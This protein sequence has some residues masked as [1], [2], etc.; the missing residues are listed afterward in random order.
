[1]GPYFQTSQNI[2]SIW[3]N[4]FIRQYFF[5]IQE[6]Y[7]FNKN[8]IIKNRVKKKRKVFVLKIFF[9]STKKKKNIN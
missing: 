9:D 2:A 6:K 7:M 8:I 5:L 1:M 3:D 4:K